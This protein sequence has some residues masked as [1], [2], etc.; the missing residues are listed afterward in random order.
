MGGALDLGQVASLTWRL[1]LGGSYLFSG[2]KLALGSEKTLGK[3]EL[4]SSR[5]CGREFEQYKRM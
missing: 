5:F 2:E 1:Q 4:D 3:E